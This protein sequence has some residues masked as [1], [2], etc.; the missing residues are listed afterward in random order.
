MPAI[1]YLLSLKE[2]IAGMARS[3][4]LPAEDCPPAGYVEQAH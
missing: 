1:S 3:Y 2:K 4:K